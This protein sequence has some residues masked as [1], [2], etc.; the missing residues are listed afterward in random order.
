MVEINIPTS[1]G[2]ERSI[3]TWPG[4][5]YYSFFLGAILSWTLPTTQIC[6]MAPSRGWAFWKKMT[7]CKSAS[8][9]SKI[10]QCQQHRHFWHVYAV[11]WKKNV[12]LK[13]LNPYRV[14]SCS[15][16]M[17]D[18]CLTNNHHVRNYS[19]KGR[20]L[21]STNRLWSKTKSTNNFSLPAVLNYA[22]FLLESSTT[23]RKFLIERGDVKYSNSSRFIPHYL[24]RNNILSHL[25]HCLDK[26]NLHAFIPQWVSLTTLRL[27]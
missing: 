27:V 10:V 11:F 24:T 13:T 12:I 8:S 2:V 7:F 15:F 26:T 17:L 20:V 3:F 16:E 22:L 14:P 21:D 23:M 25:C 6:V 1:P 4:T 19:E 18:I 9:G 5:E